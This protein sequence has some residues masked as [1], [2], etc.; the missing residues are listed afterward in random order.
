MFDKLKELWEMK[1]KAEE[2][3]RE[4]E[5][6]KFSSEDEYSSVTI[7]GTLEI[8]N[9]TIKS[10]LNNNKSKIEKS[11]AENLNR[12]IRNAQFESA[13]RMFNSSGF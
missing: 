6:L 2:I 1:S 13:K 10:D 3:K 9:I 4:L 5:N 11:I 7:K 12:A 8:E